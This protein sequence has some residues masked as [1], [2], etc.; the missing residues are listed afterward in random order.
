MYIN[1]GV[2]LAVCLMFECVAV[3]A[4]EKYLFTC[5]GINVIIF[6]FLPQNVVPRQGGYVKMTTN[7]RPNRQHTIYSLQTPIPLGRKL[8]ELLQ[9]TMISPPLVMCDGAKK[10]ILPQAYHAPILIQ[11]IWLC[12]P[13]DTAYQVPESSEVLLKRLSYRTCFS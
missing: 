12:P 4:P 11:Q 1:Q 8:V 9:S 10:S 7:T 5:K 13:H 6:E 2:W 3:H